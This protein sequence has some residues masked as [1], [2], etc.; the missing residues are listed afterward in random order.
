MSLL[1][2]ALKKAEKA[3]EDAERQAKDS[4]GPEGAGSGEA[5]KHVTTRAELPDISQPLEILSED[6]PGTNPAPAAS[7]KAPLEPRAAPPEARSAGTRERARYFRSCVAGG[8][9]G[10][11]SSR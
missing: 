5:G 2:D 7:P 11:T 9:G 3:K 8:S 1:L 10:S 4:A 6:L